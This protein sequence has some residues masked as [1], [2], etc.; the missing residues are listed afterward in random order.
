MALWG[1][2]AFWMVAISNV[3]GEEPAE[4]FLQALRERGHYDLAEAYLDQMQTSPL[5][6]ESFRKTIPFERAVTIIQSTSRLRDINQWEARLS[7]AEQLLQQFSGLAD[8]PATKAKALESLA[9]LRFRQAR[10]FLVRAE[11]DRLTAEERNGHLARARTLMT[12]SISG[13]DQAREHLKGIIEQLTAAGDTSAEARRQLEPMRMTFLQVRLRA[14]MVREQLADSYPADALERRDALQAAL[15]EYLYLWENYHRYAAGVDAALYAARCRMKLGLFDEALG[16]LEEMFQQRDTAALRP[17]KREAALIAID[18]WRQKS[19]YPASAVVERLE[20][21]V[22]T[23]SRAEGN[24]PAWQRIQLELANAYDQ[25]SRQMQ[26]QGQG[27]PS[28]ISAVKRRAVTLARVVARTPGPHRDQA[29]ELLTSWNASLTEEADSEEPITTFVGAHDKLVEL[30]VEAEA[31]YRDQSSSADGQSSSENL[32]DAV[33]RALKMVHE[34]LRLAAPETDRRDLN[35]VRFLQAYCYYLLKRYY[36][37]AVITQFMVD[38]YSGIEYSRQAGGLLVDCF[39]RLYEQADDDNRAFAKQ[40]LEEA[41]QRVGQLYPG[42]PEADNALGIL[43]RL[44][45]QNRDLE[46]A[47][48]WMKQ[49][50]P[51]GGGKAQVALQ[52]SQQLWLEYRAT[53][54][55]LSPDE[56]AS[57][58]EEMDAQLA[59]AKSL[60]AESLAGM[61]AADVTFDSALSALFLAAAHV[62]TGELAAAVEQLEEAPIAPLDLIKQQHPAIFDSPRRDSFLRESYRTALNIYLANLRTGTQQQTWLAKS[63][64]VLEALR[65]HLTTQTGIDVNREMAAIYGLLAVELKQQFAGLAR[66]AEREN[67]AGN[68]AQFLGNLERQA[69]DARTLM[70][71]GVTLLET[72]Q[73]L[74]VENNEADRGSTANRIF[75]QAY[76]ALGRAEQVGFSGDPQRESRE[77][78]LQRA[79]ALTLRGMGEFEQAVQVFASVLEKK[80]AVVPIQLEAAHTLKQWAAP[81]R[82]ANTYSLGM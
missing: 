21:L 17:V 22:A 13:F 55:K 74:S 33:D 67:L 68:L 5:V 54:G 72:A 66:P 4:A 40:R 6:T 2:T 75:R 23:L 34:A 18:C 9:E 32:N 24:Q 37:V 65:Q 62:E 27:T 51:T 10:V 1:A 25:K 35:H 82:H 7:E 36:E 64:A 80:P 26:Q 41:A 20:P 42:S 59:Q 39:V 49:M 28:E 29:R 12:E 43:A 15:T 50:S 14:P 61:T 63:E 16:I 71:V 52:L 77:L 69:S 58:R 81:T 46:T 78:E 44:A 3:R 56:W 45:I 31:V 38:K 70:W 48:A 73:M 30:V 57:R 47:V 11:N 8:T 19:P 60:L 76:E 53:R 79:K